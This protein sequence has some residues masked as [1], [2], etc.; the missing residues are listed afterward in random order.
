MGKKPKFGLDPFIN[1]NLN[2]KPRA[3]ALDE[4]RCLSISNLK[5]LGYLEPTEKG[6]ARAG[7][8]SWKNTNGDTT[9]TIQVA[10]MVNDENGVI[11]VAYNYGGELR[12]YKIQLEF[13]PSNLPNHE[14]TGYYYF[15]CPATGNRC[16]NLYFVDGYLVS[17][18]AFKAPYFWQTLS[19][20]TR[21]FSNPSARVLLPDLIRH[22]MGNPKH[23]KE[24][25]RGKPTPYGRKLAKWKAKL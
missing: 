2:E 12:T 10:A 21:T 3:V 19:A 22:E 8:V 4:Y 16:R 24:T 11:A 7:V 20:S 5:R 9:A 17:R 18:K 14:N 13:V 25:Y 1:R 23:R 6:K 15:V